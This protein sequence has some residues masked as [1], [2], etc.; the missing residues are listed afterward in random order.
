MLGTSFP[1]VDCRLSSINIASISLRSTSYEGGV[2]PKDPGNLAALEL[3]PFFVALRAG[4]EG[5]LELG[6]GPPLQKFLLLT[7]RGVGD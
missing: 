1:S 6:I 4:T 5:T 3:G 7:H 2:P